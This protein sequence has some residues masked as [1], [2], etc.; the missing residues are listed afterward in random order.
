MTNNNQNPMNN[1]V[2][3]LKDQ[4]FLTEV[5]NNI[6]KAS[7]YFDLTKFSKFIRNSNEKNFFTIF[8][9]NARSLVKNHSYFEILFAELK[10]SC[11]F[12]FDILSFDETWLCCE[13]EDLIRFQNY[14]PL[15]K[16]KT[17][18]KEGG[19]LALFIKDHISYNMRD[20]LVNPQADQNLFECI[21]IEL[22]VAP[23]TV[24]IGLIYRS[25]SNQSIG[26]LADY[27]QK[28]ALKIDKENKKLILLGDFNCDLLQ[29]NTQ[30]S[31]SDFFDSMMSS[32]L[33]PCI[34]LPTRVTENT[35]TLID[36]I[37]TTLENGTYVSG[38]ITT[39][40]SD[41]YSNFICFEIR[42]SKNISK[43]SHITYRPLTETNIA[44]FNE[45]LK[46]VDWSEVT[47]KISPNEA[48][49]EF[50]LYILHC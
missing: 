42:N 50:L 36:H 26:E 27:L 5:D 19:G 14:I 1:L 47:N 32:S 33:I 18:T 29:C 22:T 30:S 15:Y 39:D 41:H 31:V 8:N 44:K 3:E 48:Y 11:N 35:A 25:P 17:P 21:F 4:V 2:D 46:N 10:L 49:T 28:V 40:I 34:T 13:L 16:H 7:D 23:L 37:Y 38:T 45:A 12:E 6:I 24:V 43:L 20:D 9:T